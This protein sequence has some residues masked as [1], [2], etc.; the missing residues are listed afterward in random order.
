MAFILTTILWQSNTISLAY[1]D[2]ILDEALGQ[3][4]EIN[5]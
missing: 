1:I 5:L 4:D 2:A 3:N